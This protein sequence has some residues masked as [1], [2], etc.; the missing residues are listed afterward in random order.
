MRIVNKEKELNHRHFVAVRL[1][2]ARFHK[3]KKREDIKSHHYIISYDPPYSK[4]RK[5]ICEM[6]L[7][8]A[9]PHPIILMNSNP[10][11]W[12]NFRSL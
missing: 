6:R 2:D 7:T 1:T 11:F 5:N 9:L 10:N 12:N 4:H 3:N 8:N